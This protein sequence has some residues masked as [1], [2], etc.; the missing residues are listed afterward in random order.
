MFVD[1]KGE[2]CQKCERALARGHA[3]LGACRIDLRH[4]AAHQKKESVGVAVVALV[5][6][7]VAAATLASGLAKTTYVPRAQRQETKQ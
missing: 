1:K 5:K 6:F 3:K 4:A 7:A 2:F